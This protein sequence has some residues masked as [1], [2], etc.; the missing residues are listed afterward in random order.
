MGR[1]LRGLA[2][3]QDAKNLLS[4]A[5]ESP[6][7]HVLGPRSGGTTGAALG[8]GLGLSSHGECDQ[9]V[10]PAPGSDNNQFLAAL[11]K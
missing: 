11:S 6:R 7:G 2:I 1:F 10:G 9:V 8:Q 3:T 5:L 4:V